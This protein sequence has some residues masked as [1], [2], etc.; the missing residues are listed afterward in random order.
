MTRR[1]EY[2]DDWFLGKR[3]KWRLSVRP[4]SD[5]LNPFTKDGI[6]LSMILGCDLPYGTL[7]SLAALGMLLGAKESECFIPGKTSLAEATS[8]ATGVALANFALADPFNAPWVKL[9]MN[10]GD[11]PLAKVAAARH[12]GA[13]V[14]GPG[15]GKSV[16]EMAK[17][18][19]KIP[20]VLHLNQYKNLDNFRL[21]RDYAVRHLFKQQRFSPDIFVAPLGTGGTLTGF[22]KG[23]SAFEHP[24]TMVG[25]RCAPGVEIPG[26]R[27]EAKMRRD[28]TIPWQEVG[29]TIIDMQSHPAYLASN[30]FSWIHSRSIGPS[31][32]AAYLGA[33]CA[34]KQY[35]ESR[36]LK[37]IRSRNQKRRIDVGIVF[38]DK[39][40]LY[41]VDRFPMIS[42]GWQ[43]RE[44][45]PKPWDVLGW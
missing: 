32:G 24:V 17:E 16:I 28:V 22:Y 33:L 30:W 10:V 12:A 44:T 39:A 31:S 5:E 27:D 2:L 7:K 35:K 15:P 3:E 38:H 25:V 41:L 8:G 29:A 37:E 26:M 18:C 42:H 21:Y 9:F 11:T 40:D 20:G 14:D 43:F 19:G 1:N 23:F 13:Q 6:K 34:L 36:R 4:I 45:A